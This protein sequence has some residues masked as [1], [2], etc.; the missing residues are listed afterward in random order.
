MELRLQLYDFW[1]S[2]L[3]AAL[4]YI[5]FEDFDLSNC[6]IYVVKLVFNIPKSRDVTIMKLQAVSGLN[7]VKN[8][9]T[10]WFQ[11]QTTENE[12]TSCFQL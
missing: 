8:E 9:T 12:A 1:L 2:G 5:L 3:T 4:T 7:R 11:F 6:I 10:S